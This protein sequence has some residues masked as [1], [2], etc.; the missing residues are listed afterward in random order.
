VEVFGSYGQYRRYAL[1]KV[2]GTMITDFIFAKL[3]PGHTPNA[4][5][6]AGLPESKKIG[7]I[8]DAGA[9]V[10]PYQYSYHIEDF[11]NDLAVVKITDKEGMA[12]IN[13]K[14]DIVL[15]PVENTNYHLQGN[16]GVIYATDPEGH[17]HF[18]NK[19]GEL[20]D[21][22]GYEPFGLFHYL[23]LDEE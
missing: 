21:L 10:I 20:I 15:P 13:S 12:V 7:F 8:D 5:W 2:D 19:H 6:T 11:R 14:G 17:N 9:V 23:S 18:Y 16:G 22:D 3:Q 4:L 1:A